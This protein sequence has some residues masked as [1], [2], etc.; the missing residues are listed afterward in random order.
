MNNA[1]K[2]LKIR[3][4][5]NQAVDLGDTIDLDQFK[6]EGGV[7]YKDATLITA[8]KQIKIHDDTKWH[9]RFKK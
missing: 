2:M 8:L 7:G 4:L 3:D 1:E 5:F 9:D 6:S